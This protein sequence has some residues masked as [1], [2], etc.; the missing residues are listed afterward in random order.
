MAGKYTVMVFLYCIKSCL[1]TLGTQR[2]DVC[3]FVA[4]LSLI[5][6]LP[7]QP[8]NG[9]DARNQLLIV[10]ISLPDLI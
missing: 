2:A 7:Q 10:S 5:Q 9:T 6:Y 3:K 1:V 4:L 8:L